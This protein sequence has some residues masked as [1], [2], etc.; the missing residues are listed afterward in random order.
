MKLIVAMF[1][2]ISF[3]YYTSAATDLELTV[4][5]TASMEERKT[6]AFNINDDRTK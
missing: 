4:Y 6:F 5:V 2:L 1:A 3:N